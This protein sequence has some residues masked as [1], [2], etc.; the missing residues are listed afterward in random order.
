MGWG[1][2]YYRLKH[3]FLI[4]SGLLRNRFPVHPLPEQCIDLETWRRMKIPFFFD[5]K[6]VVQL[7]KRPNVLLEKKVQKEHH[8]RIPYFSDEYIAID[9]PNPWMINPK[10]GHRYNKYTHWTR[11]R[12]MDARAG[13]IKYVWERSRFCYL[14]DLV[15]YDHHFDQDLA[16]IV[17]DTMLDW[18]ECNPINC[19][20]NYV[21]SQEISLRVL[22]WLFCLHYY[23]HHPYL[24]EER[25]Q[26]IMHNIY[27][28]LHHV[29]AN[30]QFS[31][32]TVRNNHAITEAAAL[33]I[34]GVYFPFFKDADKWKA[35]GLTWFEQ[36]INYQVYADGSYLQSSF[37]YHR[38]VI[39][40]L[41]WVIRICALN[42][43]EL[44]HSTMDK[45]QK[46]LNFLSAFCRN[47]NG[48]LPLYGNHDGALFFPLTDGDPRDFRPQLNGLSIVLNHTLVFD[49][50]FTL[51]EE[52]CWLTNIDQI[53]TTPKKRESLGIINFKA[54]GYYGFDEQDFLTFIRCGQFRDRPG[55]ADNLHLDIWYREKNLFHD[56]GTYLYNTDENEIRYFQGSEGHNIV[57]LGNY[58]QMEKGPRFIWMDWTQATDCRYDLEDGYWIFE[59]RIKAFHQ[60]GPKVIHK[61]VVKKKQH[62]SWW[63]ISDQIINKPQAVP[64]IQLWHPS[65]YAIEN[66]EIVCRDQNDRVVKGEKSEGWYS[67]HY[68]KKTRSTYLRF[69]VQDSFIKTTICRP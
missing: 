38:I 26:Q 36:E 67:D 47:E 2:V 51:Q 42:K 65:E 49:G 55:H 35:D 41:S 29:Y 44:G 28:Q 31:L 66:L 15:R 33:L 54:G 37:N 27:W 60:L 30:I 58:D 20:P 64:L 7:P 1:Y 22:N 9:G 32:K 6:D 43:I 48:Y 45:A 17:F 21:C 10:T 3:I 8:G 63:E 5:Y 19:G 4:R 68:G 13:D 62:E 46:S 39:Q 59:G 50:D 61:R 40:L 69:T 34:G 12:E 25:F 16:Q 24:T 14:Y 11:I 56:A 52:A 18:I 57:K 23:K 53:K